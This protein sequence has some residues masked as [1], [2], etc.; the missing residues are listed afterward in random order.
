MQN[1]QFKSYDQLLHPYVFVLKE[2]G[3]IQEDFLD[4]SLLLLQ[5][6][7][8]DVLHSPG[9]RLIAPSLHIQPG[10]RRK[11]EMHLATSS[12]VC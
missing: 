3:D 9:S 1:A 6:G 2:G 10:T 12:L 8:P 7:K 11:S 5:V 4:Y